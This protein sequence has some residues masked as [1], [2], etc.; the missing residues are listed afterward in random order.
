MLNLLYENLLR[1]DENIESDRAGVYYI[2]GNYSIQTVAQ[3]CLQFSGVIENFSSRLSI[4]ELMGRT[5]PILAWLLKRIQRPETSVSQ[6]KQYS[7]EV[8]AI[9]LQSTGSNRAKLIESDG[10]EILLQLL[11]TYRKRDPSKGTE[12]EEYVEN[13]F[14]CVTCCAD[15][16]EGKVKFLVA[17]GIE[18]CLIMLR[19]GKMSKPRALRL[20]DHALGGP[21][22]A[23]CCE[24]LV[25][26][27]GL[28]V[29]FS[30]FM[31]KVQGF[32]QISHQ[33]SYL[34]RFS[35]Y[36]STVFHLFSKP[37]S[38]KL[39]LI[40][41]DSHTTEH[42]LGILS[43]MFRSLPSNSDARIRLL[44]KFVEKEYEKL[45]RLVSIRREITSK[46][47]TIDH[48]IALE[49]SNLSLEEQDE[50]ADEWFSRKLDAGLFSLQVMFSSSFFLSLFFSLS[51][52]WPKAEK[53][54]I[55]HVIYL[56]LTP[57]PDSGRDL[58]SWRAACV[59]C[60]LFFT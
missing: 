22:G 59:L 57:L 46:M 35:V 13:L 44:A 43:S 58:F 4:A 1:L 51:F 45:S 30:I 33:L 42:V 17:E 6:N 28:K 15:D 21:D 41:H 36:A 26:A 60:L 38:T 19:E 54:R 12:E 16:R 48:E 5:I 47:S 20:L 18:L 29:I 24:K 8:L 34:I 56:S 37:K 9:L 31:K 32:P 27:V 3:A 39:L 49:R 10:I 52:F 14:D 40:Q 55:I 2:L 25:E 11:S 53:P 7:T 23:A 50:R